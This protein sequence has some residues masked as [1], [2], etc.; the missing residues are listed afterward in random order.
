MGEGRGLLVPVL[1]TPCDLAKVISVKSKV[2][3]GRVEWD[4]QDA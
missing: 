4:G 3:G 2:V 1:T